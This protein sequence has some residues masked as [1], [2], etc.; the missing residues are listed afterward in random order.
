[1]TMG[2]LFFDKGDDVGDSSKTTKDNTS[3]LED[4]AGVYDKYN[5]FPFDI[6]EI[7]GYTRWLEIP[8][9]TITET[10][11]GYSDEELNRL[12]NN[13]RSSFVEC[14]EAHD[15]Y[16]NHGDNKD[17]EKAD[18]A[19]YNLAEHQ[20]ELRIYL[21]KNCEGQLYINGPDSDK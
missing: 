19:A 20:K 15:D 4:S 13:V 6:P 1:M 11:G 14:S 3:S 7:C 18:K 21:N 12:K 16:D 10:S 5:K 8:E 2:Y 9:D 17:L